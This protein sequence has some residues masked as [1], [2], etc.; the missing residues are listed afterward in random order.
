MSRLRSL[1]NAEFKEKHGSRDGTPTSVQ[2]RRPAIFRE[3]GGGGAIVLDK[4]SR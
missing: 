4:R 1:G 2:V 3:S